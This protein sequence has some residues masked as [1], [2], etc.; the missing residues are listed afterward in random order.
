MKDNSLLLRCKGKNRKEIL[1]I[2][3]KVVFCFHF[4]GIDPSEFKSN[5]IEPYI[6]QQLAWE[7]T[8]FTDVTGDMVN[9]VE[10][11]IPDVLITGS[12]L[13]HEP[14]LYRVQHIELC[15]RLF[16]NRK[17]IYDGPIIFI[18]EF[19]GPMVFI[20][21]V[22]E[23]SEYDGVIPDYIWPAMR[24]WLPRGQGWSALI[25]FISDELCTILN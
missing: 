10:Q 6:D 12:D 1:E 3:L 5:M 20:A 9:V 8:V 13:G 4:D 23:V 11:N 22:I 24:Q 19:R 17:S 14:Y 2:P 25:D 21:D 18:Q 16:K 15:D 7:L